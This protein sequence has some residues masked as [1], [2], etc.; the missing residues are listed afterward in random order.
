MTVPD[1]LILV[2]DPFSTTGYFPVAADKSHARIIWDCAWS[3]EGD[4]FATSSRDKTVRVSAL[5]SLCVAP[6]IRDASG[7]N[8]VPEG[9]F[10]YVACAHYVEIRR[11]SDRGRLLS[12]GRH[13][14]RW[15]SFF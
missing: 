12:P 1:T 15:I 14:V 6:L 3:R 9:W 8:L 11:G 10:E 5:V 13:E 7:E 4:V 2:H